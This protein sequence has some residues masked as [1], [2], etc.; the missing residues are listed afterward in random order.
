M[1]E[2]NDTCKHMAIEGASV[3]DRSEQV[4]KQKWIQLHYALEKYRISVEDKKEEK[5]VLNSLCAINLELIE[6][7]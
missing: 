4:G 5:L 1:E 6:T 2:K 3:T 7:K